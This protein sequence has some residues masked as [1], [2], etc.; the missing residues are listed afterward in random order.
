[1]NIIFT[2]PS[3][4]AH[5][6]SAVFLLIAF[7]LFYKHYSK[8]ANLDIFSLLLLS[9]LASISVSMH[10]ISHLGLEAVYNFNP[11]TIFNK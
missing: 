3:F 5:T 10:S 8:I 9:L 7:I 2:K 6:F 11:F 1:M 4:Y